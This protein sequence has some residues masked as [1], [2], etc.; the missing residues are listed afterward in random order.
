MTV[1]AVEIKI[2]WNVVTFVA[3]LVMNMKPQLLAVP[4]AGISACGTLVFTSA[5]NQCSSELNGFF[6]LSIDQ[7]IFPFTLRRATSLPIPNARRPSQQV[8]G[9]YLVDI[10]ISLYG[11]QYTTTQ[12]LA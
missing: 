5:F 4:D 12:R 6:L 3:I 2:F 11:S 10:D 8:T 7:Y 1:R 9:V